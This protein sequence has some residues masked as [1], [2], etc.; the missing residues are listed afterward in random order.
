MSGF[1][2]LVFYIRTEISVG[3]PASL[4]T[5]INSLSYY[6]SSKKM[7]KPNFKCALMKILGVEVGFFRSACVTLK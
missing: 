3:T 5:F 4:F 2:F 6:G 1:F 7:Q